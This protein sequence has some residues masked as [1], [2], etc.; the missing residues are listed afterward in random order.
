[1][2]EWVNNVLRK[3]Q[4]TKVYFVNLERIRYLSLQMGSLVTIIQENIL[5]HNVLAQG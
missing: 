1:M 4:V 2:D 5:K 3:R